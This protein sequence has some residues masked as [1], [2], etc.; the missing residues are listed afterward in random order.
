MIVHIGWDVCVETDD[1][2][3]IFS[4]KSMSA[5]P[6][7]AAFLRGMKRAGRFAPCAEGEQAY[8]LIRDGENARL[9]ASALH[10]ET[11][12]KRIQANGLYDIENTKY[13]L[14]GSNDA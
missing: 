5:S 9:I 1:I 3:A 2:V 10:V 11:L 14:Y 4:K 12:Q 7:A 6:D 13:I 8:L